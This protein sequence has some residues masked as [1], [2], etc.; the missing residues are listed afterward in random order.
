M[1]ELLILNNE[2]TGAI[3]VLLSSTMATNMLVSTIETV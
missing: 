1:D 3:H 2:L